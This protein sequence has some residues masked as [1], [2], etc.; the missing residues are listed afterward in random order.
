MK[1]ADTLGIC[2]KVVDIKDYVYKLQLQEICLKVS[3]MWDI[4]LKVMDIRN[5]TIYRCE[6]S[7]NKCN[8][9]IGELEHMKNDSYIYNRYFQGQIIRSLSA[10]SDTLTYFQ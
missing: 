10:C 9:F 5:T 1:V 3:D 4:C 7:A 8:R 6:G 2:L